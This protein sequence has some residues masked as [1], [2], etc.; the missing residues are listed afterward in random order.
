MDEEKL[1]HAIKLI[2][3][4]DKTKAKELLIEFLK[5]NPRNETAWQKL[6]TCINDIAKKEYC[7]RKVLEINPF[8][9][10]AQA[11]LSNISEN[12][13]PMNFDEPPTK[14]KAKTR[15]WVILTIV[16]VVILLIY[17]LVIAGALDSFP[18]IP[19]FTNPHQIENEKRI[20]IELIKDKIE[21]QLATYFDLCTEFVS[22]SGED[23][24]GCGYNVIYA[25]E[26][27]GKRE[28]LVA[29]TFDTI[30][31]KGHFSAMLHYFGYQL[32]DEAYFR[33][34]LDDNAVLPENGYADDLMR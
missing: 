9:T 19:L 34:I 2:D 33:V 25:A 31:T 13:N 4:G 10:Q 14:V 21:G 20:A 16:F 22:L 27:V 18:S 11:V 1:N 8:N 15:I 32:S 12:P 24:E 28:Y 17:S 30:N 26:K 29:L 6:A 3:S 23:L 7:Y 5:Q